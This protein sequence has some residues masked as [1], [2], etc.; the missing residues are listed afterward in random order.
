MSLRSLFRVLIIVF[1]FALAFFGQATRILASTTGEISGTVTDAAT[2][3]PLDSAHV[4]AVSP[5][6]TYRALTNS[7]GYYA[8]LNV[9]PDTYAVTVSA[10]GY[11]AGTSVGNTV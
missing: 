3:A 10:D 6:G 9:Y 8:I 4:S 5:S 11:Q 7:R 2:G 1:I